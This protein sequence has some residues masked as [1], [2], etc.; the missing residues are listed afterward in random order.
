MTFLVPCYEPH[1]QASAGEGY[2]L[3]AAHYACGEILNL[4]VV[5]Y[6]STCR[7]NDVLPCSTPVPSRNGYLL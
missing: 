5:I 4:L 6:L 1:C 3:T 2:G 7:A